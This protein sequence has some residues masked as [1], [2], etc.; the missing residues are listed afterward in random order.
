MSEC[1]EIIGGMRSETPLDLR[2]QAGW[3]A[4]VLTRQQ[5]LRSGMPAGA[6]A[7]RL[8]RGTWRQVYRGV[9]VTFTGPL[10]RGAQL[11]AAVLYA[12]EGARLSHQTAA[13]LLGLIDRCASL[14]HLTVP[15][16]R[17]VAPPAGMIIH[18][19]S[20]AGLRWRFARGT[21]PHTLAEETIVDLVHAATDL[22]DVVGYVIAGFARN[23][24]SAGQLHA[25]VTARK[26]LRWR[27]ELAGIIAAAASGTHSVL[28]YRYDRDVACAHGLPAAGKQVPFTNPDG[29]RG[30]RD[31]YYDGYGLVVEL[32]GVRYHPEERRSRD[33]GRDN[34]AAAAGGATLRYGWADVTRRQCAVAAQVYAALRKR[35]YTGA[36]KPCSPACGAS[37]A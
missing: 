31:R 36:L 18:I 29:S 10:P 26:K 34:H 33:I 5:A 3:Q 11:W 14:I 24:A 9:Y 37:A 12:G 17:R 30:Y 27:G 32:D 28:E 16:G 20:R 6:V 22:D 4:G 8:K 23:L 13:E 25:A 19:S 35:G 7:W 15:A 1:A 21:P 2:R